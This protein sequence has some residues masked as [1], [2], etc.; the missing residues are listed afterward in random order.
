MKRLLFW[1]DH[2][3][4]LHLDFR[5]VLVMTCVDH[6]L[7]FPLHMTQPTHTAYNHHIFGS[8]SVWNINRQYVIN[9]QKE[10]KKNKKSR[11]EFSFSNEQNP[12]CT[13]HVYFVY[14]GLN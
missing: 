10:K 13:Q 1:T 6:L 4:I 9:Y 3:T 2:I 8:L 5:K 12:P 7:P 14:D 11:L